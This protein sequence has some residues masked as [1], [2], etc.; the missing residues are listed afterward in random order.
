MRLLELNSDG[1]FSLTELYGNKTPPYAIL[2]HTWSAD[3]EEVTFVDLMDGVGKSKPGYNKIRFCG[4]QARYDGIQHFWVDTCC[5]DKSS[6]SELTEAINSMFRWYQNAHKCYVYLSDVL[7]GNCD[8][9][10]NLL[11]S[12]WKS[13]F[14]NSRW[15][16]RS[17]TL[18]EL[19]APTSVEFFSSDGKRLGDKISMEQQV[20][21]ITGI[22]IRAL[23][24]YP[25]SEFS[26]AE[27]MSWAA[28]RETVR[29]EDKAYSLLGIFNVHMPL[30]Y[31]EGSNAFRRLQEEIRKSVSISPES[32][33]AG[34]RL[35]VAS[36]DPLRMETV[37]VSG[38]LQYAILSHTWGD[39]EVL[40]DDMRNATAEQR[41]GYSKIRKCCNLAAKHGFDYVWVDTCCIDKSSSSE[42]QE[43]I[44]SMFTW[45]KNAKICYVY[46]EDSKHGNVDSFIKCKWFTRGWTLRKYIYSWKL[47]K[48]INAYF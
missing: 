15:F 12:T 24:G 25:L 13:A 21:E 6:S 19:I 14:R 43:A 2:S 20:Y 35:L 45:Y 47:I 42:L 29:E 40:F 48:Q 23:R 5:I 18:Q 10:H 8:E 37:P 1:E 28:K 16:T 30:I 33:R 7:K 36:S 4:E 46:L 34:M 3:N 9:N 22:S 17:W 41:R 31:G 11:R 44:C 39:D 38:S 32:T 27:R 26:A